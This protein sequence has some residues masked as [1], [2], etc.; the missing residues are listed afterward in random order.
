MRSG[1]G[2]ARSAPAPHDNLVASGTGTRLRLH[3]YFEHS[4]DA[5][6]GSVALECE[7]TRLTYRELDERANRLANHLLTH[8]LKPGARVGILI[9]R[10]VEMYVTLLGV[11]KAGAT[12]VPIDP[13]APADRVAYIALDS[14]L[15]LVCTTT[16]L[17][18]S[19]A[20]IPTPLLLVDHEADA[21]AAAPPGRPELDVIGDPLCYII[22][23]SSSTGRPKGVEITQ[24]SIC[25]FINVVPRLYGVGG[26]GVA[27]GYVNRPDLTEQRFIPDPTGETNG[28]IYRTGDLGRYTEDGEIE[29]KGRADSE[30]KVRGHRVDLQE[31]ESVM[32][33][34]DSVSAAVVTLLQRAVT[35]GELASY[36]LL[37]DPEEAFDGVRKRLHSTLRRRLPPYMV[38]D[39]LEVMDTL[40][41][42]PSGKA[43]RKALPEPQSGRL[44][45]GDDKAYAAPPSTDLE[46]HLCQIYADVLHLAVE[47]ISVDA[48]LF[49]DLGGHSLIAATLVSRLRGAGSH[50]AGELS[51]LDLY[52]YP[53]IRQLGDHL[54]RLALERE[55][56]DDDASPLTP[57]SAPPRWWRI[58]ALST[59]QSAWIYFIVLFSMWP[60]GLVYGLNRGDP[61][62]TMIRQLALTLPITYLASR[63]VLPLMA[64]RLFGKGIRPGTF[65]LYGGMHLRV[66][67][68]QR[69]MTLSPLARLAGSPFAAPY[70]RLA[71][72]DVGRDCHIGTVQAVLYAQP[73][74]G[75]LKPAYRRLKKKASAI[76]D[77]VRAG[78]RYL[79]FCLGGYLAGETPGF[80][81]LPG[82]TDQY[83]SSRGAGIRTDGD[84]VVTVN[85][86]GRNRPLYFQDGPYFVLDPS[87][88]P[89]DVVARYDNGL[90]AAVVAP[91]GRGAVGVV[92]PHPEA[93][94]D[95]FVDVGLRVPRPLGLD[96]GL[97]L[98]DRV[99]RA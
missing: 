87:R 50:G 8:V 35:G 90:P 92:G 66:W 93:T 28:R 10:S 59:G 71:G 64:A 16:S 84:A 68:V 14:G 20:D 44:I 89:A 1:H 36:V 15:D 32:L 18:Q 2:P 25:N 33:E 77:F 70:L 97:D 99:M 4:A 26:P 98:V 82:D 38:P 72:A 69:T 56:D 3:H 17:E 58:L 53:T 52:A 86:G 39:Y 73:G 91:C 75:E 42:L 34:D 79:G 41:M 13:A 62:W 51:I 9:P 7:G 12:F 85:W 88:G 48:D 6:H 54:D 81:L 37:A 94:P 22:Y 57:R 43:D 95:W 29:Y 76:S 67:I 65:R 24:S 78:G 27:R 83:I 5:R 23:T 21:I 19:C 96:L 61:S 47:I 49:D 74:G 60:L 31:I 46:Q 30:V 45:G 55:F 80:G 40:P 63:W 11:Q